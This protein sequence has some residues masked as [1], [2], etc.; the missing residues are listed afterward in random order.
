[1]FNFNAKWG[2]HVHQYSLPIGMAASHGCVRLTEAD[3]KWNYNWANGWVQEGG[4]VKRNG[5]P[6]MVINDNPPGRPAQWEFT[7][8]DAVSTV[9]LPASVMDVP[10]GVYAQKEAPWASGW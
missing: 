2:I 8:S 9:N 5:T 6:V 3:A 7:G 1:L 4:R 10:S